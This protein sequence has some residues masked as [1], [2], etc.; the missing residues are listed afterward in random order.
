MNKR[1][2]I[3][4]AATILTGLVPTVHAAG[5]THKNVR[6]SKTYERSVLD[7]WT[8]KSDKPAPLVVYFHGGGF[9]TGDKIQFYRSGFIKKYHPKGVAFATVVGPLVEVPVLIS[10]VGVSFWLGRRLYG[11][12]VR[13]EP[14]AAQGPTP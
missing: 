9:K 8:V 5:P 7:I 10:L 13:D 4:V 11:R 6:Y 14:A 1:I 3:W 12:N 2:V